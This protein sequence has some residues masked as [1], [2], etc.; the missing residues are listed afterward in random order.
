VQFA[1][2]VPT[3]EDKVL[4]RGVTMVLEAIYEQDFL[5]CSYG[6]RPG[7]SQH[8]ALQ[9]VRDAIMSMRGGWILE[10]DIKDFYGSLVHQHLRIFLDRRVRDG[11]LR[12]TI[13]KWLKAGV[14][15]DG[16]IEYPDDGTPQGGVVSPIASNIYLHEVMDKW[17]EETV[18]PRLR[19]RAHQVRFA[20]DIVLIFEK[21]EDARRVLEVLPKRFGKYSLTLHPKKTRLL[22]FC[23]PARNAKRGKSTFDFLGL[24]HYW[25]KSRQGNWVVKR[26]TA[27]D[28]FQRSLRK[29]KDWC[30][31]NRHEKV[32]DQHQ[33]L[34]RKLT[35]HYN[36]YGVTGNSRSLANFLFQVTR[37]WFKWLN[38]RDQKKD[39]TWERFNQILECYPLPSPRIR[40][41]ALSANPVT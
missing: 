18:K 24:T 15:E 13:D 3:F 23:R 14:M 29:V 9:R 28:R 4:Q 41:S 31:A 22:E 8:Q 1:L 7:R 16:N 20:D 35:G 19:G 2:T 10:V 40:H 30:K 33:A 5:D 37:I 27:S 39:L 17:F 34:K 36:Y 11:V 6:F 21:E 12:R 25:G 26:K 32:S 38:R